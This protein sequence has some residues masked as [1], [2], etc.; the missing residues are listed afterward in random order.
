MQIVLAGSIAYDY[1]LNALGFFTDYVVLAQD[2]LLVGSVRLESLH[3][4]PGGNAGNIAHSLTLLGKPPIIVAT[5]GRDFS[6]Y[7]ASLKRRGID[8]STI[9]WVEEESTASCFIV[10]DQANREVHLY[11]PGATVHAKKIRLHDLALESNSLVVITPSD[12]ETMVHFM[13]EARAMGIPYLLDVGRVASQ[14]ETSQL[15]DAIT[16]ARIL[17]G[18]ESEFA[19]IRQQQGVKFGIVEG[20][21]IV[22]TT[23]GAEGSTISVQHHERIQIPAVT[24]TESRDQSGAGDAYLAGFLFG[25]AQ[26]F[27][28][29]VSGRIGSLMGAYAV[30]QTGCQTHVFT[31]TEFAQRYREVFGTIPLDLLQVLQ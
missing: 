20:V 9:T 5:V 4:M 14:F 21:P 28:L 13:T 7:H 11:Y 27:P 22:V 31:R 12:S 23:R 3:R 26:S 24:I 2:K 1:K 18:T 29:E 16:H 30:E 15:A 6:E 10:A 17:V 19:M 8:T 25:L